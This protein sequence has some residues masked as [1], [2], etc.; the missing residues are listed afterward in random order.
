MEKK[1]ANALSE[2]EKH[3]KNNELE[4]LRSK[5][6]A[7][8]FCGNIFS[9]RKVSDWASDGKGASAICP[10]CGME[11]VVGDASGI[12]LSK[13]SVEKA[14]SAYFR[15]G[16]IMKN[17]E[18]MRA[19]VD[20]YLDGKISENKKNE[21]LCIAF[22]EILSTRNEPKA[23]HILGEFY[24]GNARFR[25]AD[26]PKA[27]SYLS[28]PV[29]SNNTSAL[30]T[31]GQIYFAN[32]SLKGSKRACYECF[33]KAAALGSLD[34]LLHL[35]DCYHCGHPVKKDDSFA[36]AALCMGFNSSYD[37]FIASGGCAN[38]LPHFAYRIGMCIK[39]GWGIDAN[40]IYAVRYF[41]ICAFS[42]KV[43]KSLGSSVVGYDFYDK[44][45]FKEI[46]EIANDKNASEGEPVYDSDTFLDSFADPNLHDSY[47]AK[48]TVVSFS[49]EDGTLILDLECASAPLLVDTSSL[50]CMFMDKNTQWT[51]ES[52]SSWRGPSSFSFT[53]ILL[54]DGG[55]G[56]GFAFAGDDGA[57]KIV[58]E[59]HF[60]SAYDFVE[61]GVPQKKKSKAKAKKKGK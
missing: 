32:P 40:Y 39:N 5:E 2:W 1:K 29:L 41:L 30:V 28:D 4:I 49:E 55:E 17:C 20:S 38:M 21:D 26:Y 52:L 47:L 24:S 54:L 59:L 57:P 15:T 43:G 12:E 51:F 3:S 46:G 60:S 23:L 19:Y 14:T 13:A 56:V 53:Q 35:A 48:A 18:A 9:A 7:C 58:A 6:C 16:A 27:I 34:G 33:A 44:E 31:L 10:H 25:P 37:E 45:C 61:E 8:Y 11:T 50:C 42:C 36:F 22:C